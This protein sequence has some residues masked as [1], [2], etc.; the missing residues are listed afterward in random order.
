MIYINK[1]NFLRFIFLP[2]VFIKK[3]INIIFLTLIIIFTPFLLFAENTKLYTSLDDIN[4][5]IESEVND[6]FTYAG[7]ASFYN[8][9]TAYIIF[10]DKIE[11]VKSSEPINITPH[12]S[13]AIIGHYKVL[14]VK[15]INHLIS[16]KNGKLFWSD[17]EFD[18]NIIDNNN[19]EAQLLFKS[20]LSYLS[21][22]IKRLKYI[23]LWEPFRKLCIAIEKI[24][25]LLNSFHSFGWG[26]TIILLSLLFK[27]F[28][29]PANILL[30]R[31][32]R[33]VSII[34]ASL[35]KELQYIK[36]NFSGEEAHDKFISAHKSKGITPFYKLRPLFLSL[37]PIP[38]LIS[39]FN[40]LGELDL[41]S[42]HNFLWIKNLAYPDTILTFDHFI[43]LFGNSFNLLPIL[44]TLLSIFGTIYYQNKIIS[45]KD[46]NKQRLNLYIMSFGFFLLFYSFPSAMVLYWTFANIWQIMQQKFLSI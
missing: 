24:L 32:Q 1:K 7:L 30:I 43:P 3:K 40:V 37:I 41:I 46:L 44:M 21:H 9:E 8:N 33:K 6:S 19:L 2:T 39:I 5:L 13:L 15:S 38:F 22:P 29:L 11:R 28:V 17:I 20:E 14:I 4:F 12:Q 35:E 23:H 42:G 34:Q 26:I 36:N 31:S 27:I 18:K 45:T 10:N 25:L 16:F